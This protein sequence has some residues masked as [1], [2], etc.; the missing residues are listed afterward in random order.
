MTVAKPTAG[1]M[2]PSTNDASQ[3]AIDGDNVFCTTGAYELGNGVQQMG[4][5]YRQVFH[6]VAG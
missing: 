5:E 1:N 4:E 6:R 3:S 2:T